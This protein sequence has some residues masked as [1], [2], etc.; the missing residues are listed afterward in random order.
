MVGGKWK[1]VQIADEFLLGLSQP[2]FQ[3]LE[4]LEPGD[5]QFATETDT[6]DSV[7]RKECVSISVFQ[8]L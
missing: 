4:V 8:G 5:F 6:C 7:C 1:Q 3:E 2:G